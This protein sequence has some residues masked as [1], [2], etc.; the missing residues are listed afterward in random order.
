MARSLTLHVIGE[1]EITRESCV[2]ADGSRGV[3]PAVVIR[4]ET[5]R[6][7]AEDLV[8]VAMVFWRGDGYDPHADP[9]H[10][11]YISG[12]HLEDPYVEVLVVSDVPSS[13]LHELSYHAVCMK[14]TA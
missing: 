2:L 14:P 3:A 7:A 4:A 12:V 5:G 1:P 10:M 8:R 9:E 6:V 11:A 13:G